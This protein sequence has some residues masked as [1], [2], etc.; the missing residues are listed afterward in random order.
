MFREFEDAK[1]AENADDNERSAA[2]GRLTVALGLLD[3]QYHVLQLPSVCWT[4]STTKYGR[5]ARTSITFITS[6]PNCRLDGLATSLTM[7]YHNTTTMTDQ[8]HDELP[9]H[10]HHGRPVS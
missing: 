8:S 1:D 5:I 9:Q 10:H 2:L 4:A 3:C 6:R 7:N